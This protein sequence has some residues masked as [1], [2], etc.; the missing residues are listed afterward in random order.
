MNDTN[1]EWTDR[2]VIAGENRLSCDYSNCD[3]HSRG[4]LR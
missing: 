3:N 2:V 1:I 4:G